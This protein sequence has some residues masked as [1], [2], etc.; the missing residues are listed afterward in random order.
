MSFDKKDL[1]VTC[2][3]T[4]IIFAGIFGLLFFLAFT[5]DGHTVEIMELREQVAK[6]KLPPVVKQSFT[7]EKLYPKG[8]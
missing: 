8:E 7:T 1:I 4:A 3:C 6:E 2:V 5:I